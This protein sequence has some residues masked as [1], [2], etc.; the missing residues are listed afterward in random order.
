[1]L[2]C[3]RNWQKADVKGKEIRDE[4]EEINNN[5]NTGSKP[6]QGT[7]KKVLEEKKI[8]SLVWAYSVKV[9]EF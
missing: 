1:M 3:S 9:Q 5:L 2:Q 6:R 7:Q 8:I 4:V